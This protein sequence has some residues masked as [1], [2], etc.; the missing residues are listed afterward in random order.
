MFVC[1]KENNIKKIE[2][3]KIMLINKICPMCKKKCFFKNQFRSEK[4]I[5]K[6]CLLWWINPRKTKIIQ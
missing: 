3:E 6:L 2:G 5:Q 4:R 1:K